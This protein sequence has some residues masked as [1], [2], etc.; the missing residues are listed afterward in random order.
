MR[1]LVT[2]ALVSC[3]ALTACSAPSGGTSSAPPA[4]SAS[5]NSASATSAPADTGARLSGDGYTLT[6]PR[7]WV[8]ATA[9][10]KEIQTA[11]DTGG[12]DSTDKSAF[13]DNVN[14]V[15]QDSAEYP[16]E[17]LKQQLTQQMQSAGS[18]NIE[19][20]QN[21][22]LDGTTA[23]QVWSV[24]KVAKNAHTIQFL[25]FARQKIYV[26][27]VSTDL[28]RLKADDLA[29]SVVSGWAWA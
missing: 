14:V 22:Q 18:T 11:V 9:A 1:P 3:L 8:D 6:L 29:Q 28:S 16:L 10:F 25:A 27:T 24:T 26:L 17:Q 20:K 5:P 7:G 15:V 12:K 23:L 21:V 19:F 4:S 2:L 13:A